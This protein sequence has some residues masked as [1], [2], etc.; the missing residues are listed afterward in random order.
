M[1]C[2]NIMGDYECRCKDGY[3][4]SIGFEEE[5]QGIEIIEITAFTIIIIIILLS[6]W[7]C[8]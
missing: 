4:F 1:D 8:I 3:N 5:C 2:I 6:L 7:Q